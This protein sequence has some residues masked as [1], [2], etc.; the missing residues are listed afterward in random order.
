MKV[1]AEQ[2]GQG[3]QDRKQSQLQTKSSIPSM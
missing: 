1:Q 2:F 3:K